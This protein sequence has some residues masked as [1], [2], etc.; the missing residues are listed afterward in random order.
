MESLFHSIDCKNNPES[1]FWQRVTNDLQEGVFGSTIFSGSLMVAKPHNGL[2]YKKF[3]LT[4]SSIYLLSKWKIPK[5]KANINWKTLEAFEESQSGIIR[6]GFRLRG[7]GSQDFYTHGAEDLNNWLEKLSQVSIFTGFEDDFITIKRINKGASAV[8]HL[9]H[10]TNDNQD[11]AVKTVQKKLFKENP[12]ILE[13]TINEISILRTTD[14]PNIVKLFKV[15]ESKGA[16]HLVLEYLKGGD[17]LKRIMKLKKFDE[18]AALRF[19]YTLLSTLDYLHSLNIVHR[20]IKLENIVYCDDNL[21]EFKLVDFGLACKLTGRISGGCGTAGFIAPEIL[22]GSSY[23]TNVDIFSTGVILYILLSGKYLFVGKT[24]NEILMKNKECRISQNTLNIS[25][26]SKCTKKLLISLLSL[27]PNI[28]PSASY[29]LSQMCIK[30]FFGAE[31]VYKIPETTESFCYEK[32]TTNDTVNKS[33]N[34]RFEFM[35]NNYVH[36]L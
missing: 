33:L 26:I 17:C 18:K 2:V 10:S 14:H 34:V 8:V 24:E 11:Y 32:G 31:F 25:S 30:E 16:I 3:I 12:I 27:D 9:C 22:R 1:G 19:I 21:Q 4:K 28:R 7:S 36:A 35:N 20:D 29:A 23:T 5:F 13:S 15:Y 6:Y